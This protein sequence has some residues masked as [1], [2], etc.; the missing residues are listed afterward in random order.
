MTWE[1]FSFS[2][3]AYT[4]SHQGYCTCVLL[5]VVFENNSGTQGISH[6]DK[7]KVALQRETEEGKKRSQTLKKN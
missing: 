2:P 6:G 7:Q 1:L 4:I 5:A 3:L